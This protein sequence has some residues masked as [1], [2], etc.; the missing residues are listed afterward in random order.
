MD[1]GG[2]GQLELRMDRRPQQRRDP[3]VSDA[4]GEVPLVVEG[5]ERLLQ[6]EF[7]RRPRHQDLETEVFRWVERDRSSVAV[8]GRERVGRVPAAQSTQLESV[9]FEEVAAL[10]ALA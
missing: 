3:L 7:D 5:V 6:L 1:D 8:R 9:P 4:G 2:L 10:D